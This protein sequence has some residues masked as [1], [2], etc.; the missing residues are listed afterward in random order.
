MHYGT[1]S[2][3][4]AYNVNVGNNT[5]CTISGLE[6][7]T[8]YY[9]AATAYNTNNIE[10]PDEKCPEKLSVAEMEIVKNKEER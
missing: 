7:G 4:Y 6:E 2:G 10:V 1:I 8:T 5:S 3:V 9:F